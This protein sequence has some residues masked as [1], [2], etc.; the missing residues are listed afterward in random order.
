MRK[1]NRILIWMMLVVF[2]LTCGCSQQ[3]VEATSETTE[4][5][6]NQINLYYVNKEKTKLYPVP[7]TLEE[8]DDP[9]L[10]ALHIV[11][12]LMKDT[13][14]ADYQQIIPEGMSFLGVNYNKELEKV[15]VNFA[16]VAEILSNDEALFCKAAITRSLCQLE[17]I[18]MVEFCLKGEKISESGEPLYELYDESSFVD[19]N[20]SEGG[21]LQKGEITIY[22]ANKEGTSLLEYGKAVE[23]SNNVSL[24][25]IVIESLITG[26]LREGYYATIPAG[27]ELRKIS[28]KDGTCYVDFNEKFNDALEG[29]IDDVTIYSVVNSLCELPTIS[30]V[31]FLINGE[32]QELYRETIPFDGMFERSLDMIYTEP[33]TSEEQTGDAEDQGQE[34]PQIE[35]T[36]GN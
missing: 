30:R 28:I 33:V 27:T 25:Q 36:E 13:G 8:Q 29:V 4:L 21:Y 20:V 18:Q 2:L 11:R 1:R 35:E 19:A 23:I 24:E 9:R 12:T 10:C 15:T 34:E 17:S 3:R 31:Q 26:P 6:E 14:S 7:Y 32:K 22:F 5:Q 16:I